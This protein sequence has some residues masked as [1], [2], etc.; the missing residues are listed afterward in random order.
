MVFRQERHHLLE[1]IKNLSFGAQPCPKK[2]LDQRSSLRIIDSPHGWRLFEHG[3][4]KDE[5]LFS[6]D[7]DQKAEGASKR[8]GL[9]LS[10]ILRRAI[11]E[12]WER[13]EKK[14]KRS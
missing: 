3:H 6:R 10:D 12:Y 13:F 2:M 11:D 7:A 9:P 1:G 8:T 5:F 4:E 14:D